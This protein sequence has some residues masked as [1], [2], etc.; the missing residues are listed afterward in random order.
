MASTGF[1]PSVYGA[2]EA[3]LDL[4]DTYLEPGSYSTLKSGFLG[5]MTGSMAR[6]SAEGVHHRNTLY[7]ENFLNT[8]SLPRSIYNYAKIYDYLISQ[9][10]PSS[11][12]VLVGLYLDEVRA[13]LGAE[14]G[15]V[16]FPRGQT[17]FLGGT[18]FV[19]A[20]AV[21]LVLMEQGRVAAEYD[22]TQMDFAETNQAEYIRTY[23][24][25]QVVDTA[26]TTRTVVYLEVRI[27][28]AVS[29][30]NEFKVVSASSLETSFYRVKMPTGQQLAKF[31]VLYKRPI[32]AVYRELPA[33]FNETVTPTEAEYCFYSFTSGDE[34]EVYFSPL[35]GAFRP[36]YNSVLRVEYL[37]TTGVAGNFDFTGTP[38][39]TVRGESLTTL[40]EMVT[41]PAGGYDK[42]SLYQI[43]RGILRKILQRKNIIIESDL[44]NYL[45]AAVD[46]TQVNESLMTFVKRRD[47]IQTR[48]FAAYLMLRDSAGRVVPT[49]TASLDFEA[50]DL[51]ARGW[52]L[53]AGTLVV[54]DRR[55]S[56]YRLVAPGEY[57]DRMAADPNSFVYCI[58]FLMQFRTVPF[59][60]LVYYRNQI[61]IDAPL[62]ALPGE[63][64]SA[65]SFIANS[66]T[67]KRNSA[68][69]S[70]YQIDFPVSS[71]LAA[72]GLGAKCVVRVR[73]MDSNGNSLG[74][75]EA[76][77][78]DG[79][80]IFRAVISTADQFDTESR[81]LF[82]S[83]IWTDADEL[84][85]TQALPEDIRLRI[86]LF[87]DS[88]DPRTDVTH[89]IR[90]GRVFQLTNAF[91][92]VDTLSLYKSLE[93]VTASGMYVTT[94]GT[95]HCDNVPLVGASFFLNPRI[96]TEAMGVVEKYH[97]AIFDIFDLL[98]N[99]T[100]VDVKLYNTYGP[101][102]LYNMD[103]INISLVLDVHSRGR[104]SEDLR[105]TIIKAAAAFIQKC[106]ENDNGRFSIS[107]LTTHLENTIAD[108]AY[109]R[110]VS[111]NGVGAQ[112]AEMIYSAAALQQDNKRIPEYI[113]AATILRS[114]LDA[115]P[116]VPDI[117]VN[118]I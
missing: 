54:Y 63:T 62:A 27:H 74:Y 83:S 90:G 67:V 89:V 101:S 108:V 20:G 64:V 98:H 47:D 106:N 5:Y 3:L 118:F 110:F 76:S 39:M 103:R 38:T 45:S 70:T 69:E 84:A 15:V 107:N 82:T 88:S 1:S 36:A 114:T 112:N 100:S 32:D 93:R 8:A 41:Q 48:L 31:R 34:L 97:S 44:E 115:D 81:M 9:A 66:I 61:A 29:Q 65:D 111:M 79:T 11:C 91:Q 4:A 50:A 58:P 10:T 57:P 49:N 33:Y 78:I 19:L 23:V 30:V 60:R 87:Y 35:P 51:A 37:T 86:E 13:A 12:R 52:S 46:R 77:H 14:T 92:T 22:L 104:S 17:I 26:G 94:E 75:S 68:F 56:V 109:V 117:Q 55:N 105:Q 116:Y 85:A 113:N 28:Q 72:D 96:G 71:N 59:P 43:K 25:P 80:N 2:E 16:T 42:E 21:S 102:R 18:P 95:F 24:T 7:H 40:V 53:P 6:V 99:N 73:F